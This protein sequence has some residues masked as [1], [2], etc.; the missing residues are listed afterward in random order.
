MRKRKIDKGD[1]HLGG[2]RWIAAVL[3]VCLLVAGTKAQASEA[4]RPQ[5]GNVQEQ[6]TD[7]PADERQ[8]KPKKRGNKEKGW[9][10]WEGKR[11]Y[12]ATNGARVTGWRKIGRHTYYFKKS[13]VMAVSQ[14]IKSRGEY[15]YVG[16]KGRMRK[17]WLT[18][19]KKRYYL[20]ENGARVTGDYFIGDKGYRF[21]KAGVY[22]PGVKV[23][24]RINPNKPM[25]ALT[26]DDGPGPYTDRLLKCLKE[27]HAVATFFLVGSSVGRYKDTV[28]KAYEMGCEIGNHS[29]SH[30]QLTQ[31][32]QAAL[33]YQISSTNQAIREAS[34]HNPTLLRPPYGSYNSTVASAAGVPLILW[35]VDTLDWKTRDTQS[36]IQSVMT[37]AKDGSIV[38]MHDIHQP[39]VAAAESIIPQLK[40]KGYQ[41]VTVSELARYKKKK[42]YDGSVYSYIR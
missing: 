37:S 41:L 29:W 17:G 18:L 10:T 15:Y 27:N 31:L 42:L 36:T 1:E 39:T 9:Y 6:K 30:P 32:D 25:I 34:G 12:V 21:N 35:D 14:W 33:A 19:G 23:K 16:A 13:G 5:T 7:A 11:Y 3:F 24:S 28:K 4:Q 8:C 38:L 2:K 40:K 26:F 22:R 20:D